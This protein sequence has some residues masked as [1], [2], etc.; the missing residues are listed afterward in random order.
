MAQLAVS[1]RNHFNRIRR[2][3]LLE[4]IITAIWFD[5]TELLQVEATIQVPYPWED[6]STRRKNQRTWLNRV[7]KPLPTGFSKPVCFGREK[8]LEQLERA[9][10][11]PF[12]KST[13]IVGE[14]G[15][16]KTAMVQELARRQTE[17]FPRFWETTAA[18]LIKEL[19]RDRGWQD[20]IAFLLQDIQQLQIVL[21]VRNLKELFEIG[22][23][24][25]NSI[26]LAEFLVPAISRGEITLLSEC[27]NAEKSQIDSRSPGYFAKFQTIALAPLGK[28][29]P[30]VVKSKILL[31][32]ES[33]DIKV[34]ESGIEESI[35]LHRRFL[36]LCWGTWPKYSLFGES[37]S[38]PI[39]TA[40]C[41]KP[42]A[43]CRF[44]FLAKWHS[45]RYDRQR[46]KI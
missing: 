14:S 6:G 41:P 5:Q 22:Q 13:I 35:D 18:R 4:S 19:S 25:G 34:E 43:C 15:I 21:Y 9:L 12:N 1:I 17:G 2:F 8:E 7:A 28:S 45:K 23:Y 16:G 32:A 3:D 31:E 44:F 33:R 30:A 37:C 27:S 39:S 29:L 38:R 24:E 40:R 42:E 46:V 10:R 36:P 26:S 20:N 11:N